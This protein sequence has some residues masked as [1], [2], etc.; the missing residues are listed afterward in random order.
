MNRRLLTIT[1]TLRCI[2][3]NSNGTFAISES[4]DTKPF[5]D[6]IYPID[7]IELNDA[8]KKFKI[9]VKKCKKD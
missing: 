3:Y 5:L 4:E 2:W 8:Y 9:E 7:I 6:E 1:K